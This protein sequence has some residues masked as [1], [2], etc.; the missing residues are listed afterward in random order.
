[1]T[2]FAWA[3]L[4]LG[5]VVTGAR[6]GQGQAQGPPAPVELK[7]N[8]PNPFNPATT[9]PFSLSGD[10][11]ANGHRPRVSLKIYNV[12]AQLV[13][14]PILQGTGQDLEDLELTCSNPS[15]CSFS[16]YWDGKVLKTGREAA[17]G[18][19]IYQLIVDGRRYTKKMI[20]MK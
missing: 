17:S 19:Y 13:A 14:T 3:V 8:Y 10:L 5:L 11:F 18:V 7:Q 6:A 2:R 4:G 15:G 16:A 1:M 9:L 12:L 20:V